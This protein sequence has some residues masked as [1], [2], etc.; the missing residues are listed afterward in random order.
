MKHRNSL[1]PAVAGLSLAVSLAMALAGCGKGATVSGEGGEKLKLSKPSSVSIERGG[2]SKADLSITRTNLGGDVSIRFTDL[3]RGVEVVD[4]GN[5]IV[6]DKGT[7][8]LRAGDAADL[9]ENSIAQ[10]T[11]TGP[12]GIA[13][14]QPISISVKEK[15]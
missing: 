14:S 2:M 5:T 11:A 9:V 4:S 13:V 15:K 1:A 10:V 12:G 7:Y 8:T 6:G 3:P